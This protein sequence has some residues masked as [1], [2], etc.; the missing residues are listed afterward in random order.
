MYAYRGGGVTLLFPLAALYKLID[1]SDSFPRPSMC[2]DKDPTFLSS[3]QRKKWG[4]G[5]IRHTS[6]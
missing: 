5:L 2:D 3:M 4:R 6:P 1:Q